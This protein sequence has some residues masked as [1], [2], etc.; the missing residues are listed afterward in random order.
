MSWTFFTVI[1]GFIVICAFALGALCTHVAPSA[2]CRPL[3]RFAVRLAFALSVIVLGYLCW[4]FSQ[5]LDPLA[6]SEDPLFPR[7]FPYPDAILEQ[8]ADW[9]DARNPARPGTIKIHGEYYTIL[10]HLTLSILVS[11]ALSSFF[12]GLLSSRHKIA[13]IGPVSIRMRSATLAVAFHVLLI[14]A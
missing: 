4:V 9:L 3:F 13:T 1:V 2:C 7:S 14:G 10:E 6:L 11:S 12:V 5:E 8:Y